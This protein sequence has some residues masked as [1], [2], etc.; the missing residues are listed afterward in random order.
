MQALQQI[1]RLSRQDKLSPQEIKQ[2][3]VL[4]LLLGSHAKKAGIHILP[5][6]HLMCHL[7]QQ[8]HVTEIASQITSSWPLANLKP[9]S[10]H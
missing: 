5:K 4:C 7:P 3:D 8:A 10:M 9:S 2:W 6:Y 1:A